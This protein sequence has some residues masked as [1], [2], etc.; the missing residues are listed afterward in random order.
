MAEEAEYPKIDDLN[1]EIP[2]LGEVKDLL[3]NLL[4]FN[5]QIGEL[6]FLSRSNS[7]TLQSLPSFRVFSRTV[8]PVKVRPI[9]R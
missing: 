2:T 5:E 9:V 3:D 7:A 4:T 6:L 8:V 1:V